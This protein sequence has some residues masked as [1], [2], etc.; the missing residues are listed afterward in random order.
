MAWAPDYLIDDELSEYE[1][2][3][4]DIDDSVLDWAITTASRSIDDFTNR[5]FGKAD[6]PEQLRYT[7]K[8]NRRKG[9]W[10]IVVEDLQDLTGLAVH[11]D[12]DGDDVFTDAVTGTVLKLPLNAAAKGKPYEQLVLPESV[13]GTL[14][15]ADGEVAVTSIPGWNAI[16]VS[17]KQGTALQASRLVARRAAPFGIAGSPETGSEMRL[18]AKL[19]PDV[20]LIVKGFWRPK[21]GVR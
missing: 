18:L 10:S 2:I 5:Q 21:A 8:W 6:A 15:G 12:L 20:Q 1:W 16:P 17:I 14:C 19:D 7:P 13:N 3:T 11:L 9:R 4:D